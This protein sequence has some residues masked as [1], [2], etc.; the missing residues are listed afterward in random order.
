MEELLEAHGVDGGAGT[1]VSVSAWEV[2][3]HS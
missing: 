3:V 2:K 1:A